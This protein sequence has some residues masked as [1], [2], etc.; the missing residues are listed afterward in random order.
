MATEGHGRGRREDHQQKGKV[1]MDKE[2]SEVRERM[3]NLAF[4]MQQD[5][6]AHWVY[7]WPMKKKGEMASSEI[8][9]QRTK[10]VDKRMVEAC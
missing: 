2:L 8:V 1:E 10:K 9:G 7:E 4:K 3:E 5:A 6:K